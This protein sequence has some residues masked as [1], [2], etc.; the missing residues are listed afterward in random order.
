MDLYAY[1]LAR[2]PIFRDYVDKHYGDIPR[3]RG[4]RFM[5]VE[6]PIAVPSVQQDKLFNSHCGTDVIYIHTRC[7]N[8]GMAYDDKNSNYVACGAAKWEHSLGE[9]FVAHETDCCDSTYCDHYVHAVI[10][11]EYLN[12]IRLL[13]G[14]LGG[15]L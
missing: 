8:C 13:E 6:A 14:S 15:S 2:D 4:I 3:L 12:I 7:G 9:A 1:S 11:E 10:D 5:K